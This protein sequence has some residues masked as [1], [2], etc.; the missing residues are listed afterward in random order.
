MNRVNRS[1]QYKNTIREHQ[2]RK[3]EFWE[4]YKFKRRFTPETV[5]EDISFWEFKHEIT[6]FLKDP[7]SSKYAD[8][9]LMLENELTIIKGEK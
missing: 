6:L 9:F 3:G 7:Q 5:T 8:L 4:L 1:E 2:L